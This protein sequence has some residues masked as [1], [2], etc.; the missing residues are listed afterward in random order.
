MHGEVAAR[1]YNALEDGKVRCV[2]CPHSCL[3]SE[4]AR[5]ICG[6]RVNRGGKLVA[7]AYGVYPAIHLDPIEKKPL[8][9]FLPGSRILSLG[10]IGCNLACLHC[11]N[12]S[13]SCERP[14]GLETSYVPPELL[15]GK[16]LDRGSIGVAFTYNEP[17]INF[18]Y[19]MD[20]S[21]GIRDK[22]G[23]IVHVTNGHL[24]EGPWKELMEHTDG[25]N[26]DVKGFTQEFYK[27]ITGGD[28]QPVLDN[29]R[30]S[31]DMGVHV[32]IA[33]LVIPGH[34]D[35]DPQIDG[36]IGWVLSN[37]HEQVPVHFNRFH[38]DHRMMDVPATSSNSL[39]KIRDRARAEGL[40]HVFIGNLGGGEY[41]DSYCPGCGRK[42]ISRSIFAVSQKSL[43]G[44]VCAHCGASV[45]G[46]WS[47]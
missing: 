4:G 5:G 20:V 12:W 47:D 40:K 41:N 42:V 46:V 1:H 19:I 11:Q 16:A 28:L 32:E 29:V 30:T 36:F 22:G 24:N 3:I 34:N 25:A 39:K 8:N 13:L 14:E 43:K 18:E 26:I 27:K 21:S 17:T 44:G 9:H 37:L 23:K 45:S 38:P 15:I 31:V 6:I 35:D 33:Y 2:L 10:S 7:A